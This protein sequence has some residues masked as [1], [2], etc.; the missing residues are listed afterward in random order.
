MPYIG[1]NK[2][3]KATLIFNIK[4]VKDKVYGNIG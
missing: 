4:K 1:Y 3:N 2:T